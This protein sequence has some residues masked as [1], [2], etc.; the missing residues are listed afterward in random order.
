MALT[1]K[2]NLCWL[3]AVAKP[4]DKLKLSN[5]FKN[6]VT[7]QLSGGQN[8]RRYLPFAK[9]KGNPAW[10]VEPDNT[11]NANVQA[12]IDQLEGKAT[13]FY[14]SDPIER[15]HRDV[16]VGQGDGARLA[17]PIPFLTGSDS[18]SVRG[19]AAG[20]K[21]APTT[22]DAANLLSDDEAAMVG[23]LGSLVEVASVGAAVLSRDS[24]LS[25]YLAYSALV[26]PTGSAT[27]Y[28]VETSEVTVSEGEIYTATGWVN[29][30]S[31]EDLLIQIQWYDGVTPLAPSTMV[32]TAGGDFAWV[33][34]TVTD[35]APAG[36]TTAKVIA[37]L[38]AADTEP[39][40]FDCLGLGPLHDPLWWLPSV[41][42]RVAVFA[43]APVA[44]ETL[45]VSGLARR[46]SHWRMTSDEV[47]R[48]YDPIGNLNI[49]AEVVEIW[50][51]ES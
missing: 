9:L 49:S 45:Y 1:Q 40:W 34:L 42:P 13:Q 30:A 28:G 50:E 5:M 51:N 32:G 12:L 44:L 24:D 10:M 3:E 29:T 38:N 21:L 48:H 36:A 17:F 35:T 33:P 47:A 26:T 31:T 11:N 41:S 8:T 39:I 15:F 4:M 27:N 43:V 2:R 46:L 16:F 6:D 14:F 7:E 23:G 22:Y 18:F 19:S 20:G 37:R 25:Y